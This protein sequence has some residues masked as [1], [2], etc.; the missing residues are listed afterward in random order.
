MPKVLVWPLS[1]RIAM[2]HVLFWCPDLPGDVFEHV[3]ESVIGTPV[4]DGPSVPMEHCDPLV[5]WD[6]RCLRRLYELATTC[7]SKE[8]LSKRP[9]AQAL[10]VEVNQILLVGE[11]GDLSAEESLTMTIDD[12]SKCAVC[13]EH[14]ARFKKYQVGHVGYLWPMLDARCDCCLQYR[15][16]HSLL[17]HRDMQEQ[18]LRAQRSVR[19]NNT[20][21]LTK[22]LMLWN[23]RSSRPHRFQCRL[24]SV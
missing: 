5:V 10:A 19:K 8:F 14:V 3:V 2:R 7:L 17:S 23:S 21:A 6:K 15:M 20:F 22:K 1:I 24:R 13:N 4:E 9:T 11:L 12:S 18:A 16:R